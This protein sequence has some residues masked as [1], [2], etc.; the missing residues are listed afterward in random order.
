M[1]PTLT[2][3]SLAEAFLRWPLPDSVCADLCATR[4]GAG[5]VGTNLLS[6]PE[7]KQMMEEVVLPM[8]PER[9]HA[10]EMENTGLSIELE[11]A[12][13][14]NERLQATRLARENVRLRKA[15]KAALPTLEEVAADET[16]FWGGPSHYIAKDAIEVYDQAKEA[17]KEEAQ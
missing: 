4:Q 3:T 10:L 6:F 15:L 13:A 1:N 12:R 16:V 11:K 8:W 2:S 17:L 7:A 5:R 14:E 9:L